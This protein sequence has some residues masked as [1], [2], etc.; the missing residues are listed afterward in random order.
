VA[1]AFD[2]GGKFGGLLEETNGGDSSG[3][4]AEACG[5]IFRGNPTDG[6]RRDADSAA[7]FREARDALRRSEGFFRRGGEDRAEENVIGAIGLGFER[8]VEAVARDADLELR[9]G[10]ARPAPLL[11]FTRG[12]RFAAQV[13][14]GG[15]GSES[16][17][18][19]VIH[20]DARPPGCK[21]HALRRQ[22]EQFARGQV[23]LANL[24]PVHARSHNPAKERE[25][26]R[27][28]SD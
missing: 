12:S 4:R 6:E 11:D 24:N 15:A 14:A 16:D 28:R 17:V 27:R 1:E 20:E 5:G 26:L 19:A 23:F 21:R 13:H 9:R 10:V 7:D 3:A 18:Q 8:L 25:E 22:V 2:E